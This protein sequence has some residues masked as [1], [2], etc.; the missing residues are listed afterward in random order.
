[1]RPGLRADQQLMHVWLTVGRKLTQ[2]GIS[3]DAADAKEAQL[4]CSSCG[5][6]HLPMQLTQRHSLDAA[7]AVKWA[8]CCSCF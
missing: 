5:E 8:G 4:G 6:T 1:M 3:A 7:H 2:G